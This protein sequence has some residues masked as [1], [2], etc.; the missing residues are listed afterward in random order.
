MEVM[1]TTEE[2]SWESVIVRYKNDTG[3]SASATNQFANWLALNYYS[4]KRK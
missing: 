4:P 3:S 1:K 2:E